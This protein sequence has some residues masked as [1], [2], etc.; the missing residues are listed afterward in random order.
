[1]ELTVH[2]PVPTA[3]LAGADVRALADRVRAIVETAVVADGSMG[4][5]SRA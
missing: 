3:G 2:P 1:V 5:A 4:G